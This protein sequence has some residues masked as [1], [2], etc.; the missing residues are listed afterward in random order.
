MRELKGSRSPIAFSV[1]DGEGDISNAA[2]NKDEWILEKLRKLGNGLDHEL[3]IDLILASLPNSFAHF[4][5][6]ES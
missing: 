1:Q 4:V 2:C 3:N 5:L 6:N